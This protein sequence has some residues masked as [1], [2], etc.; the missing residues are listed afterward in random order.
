MLKLLE[1]VLK[2]EKGQ[3]IY[4]V[5]G[6]GVDQKEGTAVF[7]IALSTNQKHAMEIC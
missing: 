7:P 3:K 6:K 5:F 1:C 4:Q 2:A